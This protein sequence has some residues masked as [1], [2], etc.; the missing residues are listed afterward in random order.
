[1][2]QCTKWEVMS[3]L[4]SIFFDKVS[5]HES[6]RAVIREREIDLL[7]KELLKFF[8]RTFFRLS[9]ATNNSYS[10]LIIN[11]FSSPFTHC[12]LDSLRVRGISLLLLAT[13]LLTFL[14]FLLCRENLLNFINVDNGR[15][16]LFGT[17][18]D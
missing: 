14:S 11:K 17:N 16:V 13:T 5:P 7:I 10:C 6:P 15:L 2:S 12:F 9:C 1:M 18:H 4:A 3:D 8:L